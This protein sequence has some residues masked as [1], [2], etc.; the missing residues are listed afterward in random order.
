[1]LKILVFLVVAVAADRPDRRQYDPGQQ[2]SYY[3]NF[4][5]CPI[6]TLTTTFGA[7]IE[8]VDATVT[9]NRPLIRNP[10]IM[11]ELPHLVRERIPER[12]VHAKGAGG[13]GYFEVTNDITH[14]CDA[15]LF[16]AVGKKTP[17]AIRF[18]LVTLEKAVQDTT[19]DI[20]GF[21]VKFYTEEGNLDLVALNIE[22]FVFRDPVMFAGFVRSLKRN[23]ATNLR[24]FNMFWDFVTLRPETVLG[25]ITL[26]SDLGIPAS[27]RNM[28]GFP[29][30]T[31]EVINK[32]NQKRFVRFHFTPDAGIKNLFTEQARNIAG[33]DPDYHSRDL[34]R[35]IGNG[36]CP[37]WTLSVQVLT[38]EDVKNAG[39]DVF[40]VTRFLPHD[41]YPLI[42]VGKLVLNKNPINFFAEIEQLALCPSNLVPKILG[43]V[44]KMFESRIFSYRDAQFYRLGV[45]FNKISVNTPFQTEVLTYTRD[46]RAPVKDNGR[47]APVYYP[48]SFNGPVPYRA[49][50]RQEITQIYEGPSNNFDQ[51][52]EVFDNQMSEEERTRLIE[53]IVG[54]LRLV[55]R[56]L[57]ERAVKMFKSI[58][59]ELGE[60]IELALFGNRTTTCKN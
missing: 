49:K 44:D 29:I 9:L 8:Y 6:G 53:N 22:A 25:I 33:Q 15:K 7:P 11:D 56:V 5:K 3:K 19:R 30:H 2:L 23:P 60:R 48:N 57:Q 37:S 45:N 4:T 18:S 14:I 43:G 52:R 42:P 39:F 32:S 26:F 35:A 16:S 36:E 41:K 40:D 28:P 1:M 58:H 34:Y 12:V 50:K 21:A 27:Y 24:D 38:P 47:D 55:V 17:I 51:V 31:Y 20:R 10:Y 13:F 59:S 54:T 46:G